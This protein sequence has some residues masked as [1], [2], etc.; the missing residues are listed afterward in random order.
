[1][2]E[3]V[4]PDKHTRDGV[5]TTLEGAQLYANLISER[6]ERIR[7]RLNQYRSVRIKFDPIAIDV[8]SG[9]LRDVLEG[10]RLV[11]QIEST[12]PS[13]Q[14]IAEVLLGP[15][16]PIIDVDNGRLRICVWDRWCHYERK[17]YITVWSAMKAGWHSVDVCVLPDAIDYSI[18][19]RPF[20]F[21][22]TKELKPRMLYGVN[23]RIV[24]VQI[25]QPAARVSGA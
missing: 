12:G 22:G 8:W 21:T 1:L 4:E 24:D 16:S 14:V 7:P 6:L 3:Y 5:H 9:H 11:I 19:T 2:R 10:G 25:V 17:G 23:C 18:C 13:P 20:D 15:S